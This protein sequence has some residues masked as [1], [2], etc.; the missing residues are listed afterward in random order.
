MRALH[1]ALDT[2]GAFCLSKLEFFSLRMVSAEK[3]FAQ[4][5]FGS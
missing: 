1:G 3:D 2:V 4:C 5:V